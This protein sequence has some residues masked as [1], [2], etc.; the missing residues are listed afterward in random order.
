M[1]SYT[2]YKRLIA[3]T[4][5]VS[6][7]TSLAVAFLYG[8][9][10]KKQAVDDLARVDARKTSRLAFE[11]LYSAMEKGW[12]KEELDAIIVRLNKVEPKMSINAYRSPIVAELFGDRNNDK[13]IR[14]HDPMVA[15]AMKG[16]EILAGDEEI[17]YLYPIVVKQ[18][19]LSCHTNAKIG[20]INGVIDVRFPVANLKISLTTMIN[21]FII[22]FVLF[23]IVIFAILYY[24]LNELLVQPIKQF[25]VMIQDI[26]SNNDMA[27]RISL[28]TKILEVKNIE[29][30]FNKMLDSIQDYYEKLQELS[31]RDYLTGLYNRRK[32]EEFLTYEVMRSVRHHHKF[33]VL[34]I[35]L[36][37]FKYINDTYGHASGDL[38]LKE[39]TNIFGSNLRNADVLA[40]IGGDEF[41]VILP[42]TPY[43]SGYAVVEKLRSSLESTPISLMFD[44]VSLTASFGIAEYPEQGEN[45]TA[46][47][48]GSDLA[49]YKAKRA[50]KNTIARADQSDQE[51]AS[52]IQK[53]GEFL[54]RAIDE[55]C[56]EPFVQPIYD[57]QS[58]EIFGYEVL[59]RI[60]DG[61][62]YMAA[63]QFI[64]VAESLGFAPKID[65][66][67]LTKGLLAREERG[68][69]D[70]RFFFNLS[71]KSLFGGDYV[72]LIKE[73][74]E[75]NPNPSSST[76][77]TIEILERE[78]IHNV[79]GLMDIIEELKQKGISFALD[80][81]GSGF[82]SFV[83]LK[84]FDTDYVKIDGEFVK[85]I[86]VNEKDRIFVKH[87]HQIA[88]EFGKETIAEYVEDIETL[89]ILKEIGVDY[90]QGFHLG[91]PHQL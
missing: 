34:M 87:I 76:G 55:D 82:S 51:M 42:E 16:E 66:I 9:Y 24:K 17:R 40:R 13:Q 58:G 48:T 84:Y 21:S 79:N 60:R 73:H 19:C 85:N 7:L 27:K 62:R 36:D 50:G 90:A 33:T 44:Q 89:N 14:D 77:I 2:T 81:F 78:A 8:V 70:K 23:T 30:Y 15:S 12:S 29:N 46:L 43:E 38:V 41:A 71:T 18:E 53:K 64:E 25:I 1:E 57:V 22:F 75:R 6:L 91:R 74:G 28:K 31:D 54:R 86:V 88:K 32:F 35:D 83:Y 39:V 4:V 47:L 52:E 26:I 5:I 69:W 37:N 65:Q 63:G 59:A 20:D 45:I 61:Q 49:M 56:V 72:D 10:I 67:I 3:K 80:D 68:L 11:A